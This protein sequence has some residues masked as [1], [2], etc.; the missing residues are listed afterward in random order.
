LDP[1]NNA[2]AI[3]VMS[4]NDFKLIESELQAL[5]KLN[6]PNIVNMKEWNIEGIFERHGEQS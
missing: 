6:H 3:K 2:Y 5:H 1:D 4:R